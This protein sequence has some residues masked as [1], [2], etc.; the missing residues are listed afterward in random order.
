M[1]CKAT[2]NVLI[3]DDERHMA[4]ALKDRFTDCDLN[5]ECPYGFIA[6]VA[7]SVS[8]CVAKVQQ[9]S[10]DVI[11]VDVRIEQERD[12]LDVAL[13]WALTEEFGTEQPIRIVFTGHPNYPECVQALR[14]GAWDYIV[15]EDVGD[16]SAYQLV[17]NSAIVRLR[18][19]DARRDQEKQI[20]E[21][22]LPQH[23][24][25]LEKRY[26]GQIV[27]LWHEPKVEVVAHGYDAF[28]LSE[29]LREWRRQRLSWQQPFIVRFQAGGCERSSTPA[30]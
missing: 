28:E 24:P 9:R 2:K 22:W 10:Y 15:K 30:S 18:Q 21:G 26:A 11:V 27:A 7:H 12:G 5:D 23:F 17:V 14:S 1:E 25:D 3:V 29:K 6:D 20:V 19:L 13:A 8:E 4:G 16:T